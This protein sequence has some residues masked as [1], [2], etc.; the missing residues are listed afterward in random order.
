ML[1]IYRDLPPAAL[2]GLAARELA[3]NLPSIQHLSLAPDTIG[4]MLTRLM[5]AGADRLEGGE[6]E[7]R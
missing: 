1:K 3:G 6:K 5:H 2:L 4:P 7:A